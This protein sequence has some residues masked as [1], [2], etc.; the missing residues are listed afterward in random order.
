MQDRFQVV[1][2][3]ASGPRIIARPDVFG[4]RSICSI[5]LRQGPR[6]LSASHTALS[7]APRDVMGA[8]PYRELSNADLGRLDGALKHLVKGR[9][10]QRFVEWNEAVSWNML[11]RFIVFEPFCGQLMVIFIPSPNTGPWSIHLLLIFRNE[12][13]I[14]TSASLRSMDV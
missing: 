3:K 9:Q 11:L 12:E 10:I 2:E 7:E 5:A 1:I 8:W 13:R 14:K 6:A 4:P